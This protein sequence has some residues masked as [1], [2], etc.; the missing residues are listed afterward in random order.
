MMTRT[1]QMRQRRTQE[2]RFL[3]LALAAAILLII[4][5][6]ASYLWFT[7]TSLPTPKRQ[8]IATADQ[9]AA[10]TETAGVKVNILV[11]GVDHR[12]DDI[13]RSDTLFVVTLDTK[14]KQTSMLSIPRDTRVKI[15]GYGFDK[16]NHTYSLGGHKLTQRAVE[17]FLGTPIDY[18]IEIDFSGFRKIVDAVDG[19]DIAVEKRMYYEDPYDDLVIDFQPGVQHLD[20]DAA[21]KY[22]RYRDEEGDI[23]RI[24]RQQNFI[25][26]ML[27][28]ASSPGIF[29][30]LPAIVDQISKSIRTDLSISE[31]IALGKI[32]KDAKDQGLKADT[33]PS[34]PI[35]IG[36]IS[37]L[38][39]NMLALREYMA[40][41]IGFKAT[42]QYLTEA[43]RSAVEYEN[44]LP[45]ETTLS[46]E[47]PDPKPV[48]T[49]PDS[50]KNDPAKSALVNSGSAKT[51]ANLSGSK[52]VK[53]KKPPAKAASKKPS[54][55]T[56]E[57][58]A[59][60]GPIKADIIN[61]SGSAAAGDKMAAQLRQQGFV[62]TQI[63]SSGSINRNTIVIAHTTQDQVLNKVTS[64]PFNY[65]LQVSP[66]ANSG[67]QVTVVVGKDYSGR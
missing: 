7:Q 13:G 23:G 59:K 1:E 38:H 54:A 12:Q 67:T 21:I 46:E 26:A 24:A 65:A 47:K 42:E 49:K 53:P 25:R 27:E 18:F 29:V 52:T 39:P 34:T 43:K 22:V 33:V 32:L 3:K 28:K 51:T 17:E 55:K 11:L 57:E 5:T 45:E 14:T 10:A 4:A 19:V 41:V 35:D 48:N 8:K 61:A 2:R 37:Y 44:S 16:I 9:P 60:P 56:K 50:I 64:L 66:Q 20:G 62:I 6:A 30:R 15:P 36:N 63:V 40:G 31:M 58:S